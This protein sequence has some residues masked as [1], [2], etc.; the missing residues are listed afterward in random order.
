MTIYGFELSEKFNIPVMLRPT[1]RVSHARSDVEAGTVHASMCRQ[2]HFI[3]NPARRVALPGHA[4][5]LHTELIAKQA[6]IEEALEA[7]PWNK[8]E[9]EG[10]D[11]NH[12]FWH[13]RTIC[14]RSHSRSGP[15]CLT[16]LHR[17]LSSSLKIDCQ[18]ARACLTGHGSGRAGAGT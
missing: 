16:A 8:L 10:R 14:R 12:R 17:N 11:R 6:A 7:T 4:R 3:K 5:A 15:G 2:P 13:C 1:T 18:H 9:A